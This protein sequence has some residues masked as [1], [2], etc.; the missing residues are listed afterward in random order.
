MY[1]YYAILKIPNFVM[2]VSK[3]GFKAVHFIF[4]IYIVLCLSCDSNW[5]YISL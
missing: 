5:K 3:S 1:A 4:L 2:E